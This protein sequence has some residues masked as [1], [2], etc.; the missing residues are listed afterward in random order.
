MDVS[1]NIRVCKSG[2][3]RNLFGDPSIKKNEDKEYMFPTLKVKQ[4]FQ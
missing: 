2:V 1:M 4:G 3:G